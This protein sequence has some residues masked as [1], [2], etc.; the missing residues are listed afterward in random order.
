MLPASGLTGMSASAVEGA[1]GM[2]SFGACVVALRGVK[3]MAAKRD[4]P[5]SGEAGVA[6]EEV[7]A[8]LGSG[9]GDCGRGTPAGE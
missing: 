2:G 1:S 9:T 3:P 4:L 6:G 5:V 8:Q 7:T